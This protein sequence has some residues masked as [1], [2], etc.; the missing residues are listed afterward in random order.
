MFTR[1]T[2]A[3]IIITLAACG[4]APNESVPVAQKSAAVSDL[5]PAATPKAV[6]AEA[7]SLPENT[8]LAASAPNAIMEHSLPSNRAFVVNADMQFRTE[9]VRKT[10]VA[11][12]QLA[13]QQG[14]FV[15]SNQTESMVVRNESFKQADGKL[16][17]I[18]HYVTSSDVIVRVPR[19]NAMA[20]LHALQPYIT[21]LEKQ[22]YRAEDV[23]AMQRRQALTAQRE[24]QHAQDLQRL[25]QQTAS[26]TLSERERT[27]N[28]QYTAR[29]REDEA[30]I[31]QLELQDKIE[32]A[33]IALHFRQPEN[34]FK[35][36]QLDSET[37]AAEYRPTV[38]ESV[39][40]ALA[41]SVQALL[42]LFLFGLR[43]WF[44]WL[45]M[46]L[47]IWWWRKRKTRQIS[48]SLKD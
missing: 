7:V 44:V 22:N 30:K 31:Q 47:A 35:T 29:E 11:V 40:Q 21:V 26:S 37:L 43:T 12:E 1:F 27:L 16:L 14:G 38:G 25:G 39:Q 20:F 10:A 48:G 4:Q 34:V 3:T 24:Q 45:F 9:D 6:V 19:Q 2:W 42:A 28:Q 15:V 5:S 17:N 36:V 46:T 23:A 32:F 33:T 8:T 13:V 18:E 41:Y